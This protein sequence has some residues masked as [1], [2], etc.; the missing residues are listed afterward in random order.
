MTPAQASESL[1]ELR[2]TLQT[3]QERLQKNDWL[4]DS[5]LVALRNQL[6]LA[7]EQAQDM[8]VRL[9][10]ELLSVTAR[11]NQLGPVD[12]PAGESED[13]AR[14]RSQLQQVATEL[15][16]MIK[17][18][19]LIGVETTQGLDQVSKQRRVIFQA[20]LGR[21]SQSVL[22]PR[23]WR[24]VSR[25]LPGDLARV[26]RMRKD[27]AQRITDL[28]AYVL[29]SAAALAAILLGLSLWAVRG[30]ESFTINHTKPS[31]L[32]R[33]FYASA[34]IVLYC[35]TPGLLASVAAGLFY[36]NGN[37]APDLASFVSKSVFALF[38]GGFVTGMGRVL[39]SAQRPSWRLPP[40][41]SNVALKL[42]WLPIALGMMVALT[43]MSQQL[44]GLINATLS[45]TLLVNSFN[46][47]TLSIFIAIAA[48]NLSQGRD[49]TAVV[50]SGEGT[51]K[52]APVEQGTRGYE[53]YP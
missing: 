52:A 8:S 37:L 4:G 34:L 30:L 41:P 48:W 11:L 7:Q 42:A 3:V 22:T 14:Q 25:D 13:I 45:T 49:K 29:W 2:D 27:L 39:L 18:A 38:L 46:T 24:N 53:P 5:D 35:L 16:G 28:P 12:D 20:E 32:R 36:W 9:E 10:P 6:L 40:I 47:L 1:N 51:P 15:D 23:F 19:R 26:E 31:R 50:E 44:L 17:L 33:S 43:W 21:Q